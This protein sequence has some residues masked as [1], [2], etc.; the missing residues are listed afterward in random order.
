MGVTDF[1]NK[2]FKPEGENTLN[3]SDIIFFATVPFGALI[4]TFIVLFL[5]IEK[6]NTLG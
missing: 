2:H 1:V 4:G 5:V 6:K 3:D